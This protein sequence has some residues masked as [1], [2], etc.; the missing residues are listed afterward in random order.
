MPL[1]S[2]TDDCSGN[3]GDMSQNTKRVLVTAGGGGGGG[4]WGGGRK[5][6]KKTF[7]RIVTEQ[8]IGW[9]KCVNGLIAALSLLM[10]GL[11]YVH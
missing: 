5:K 1:L 11:M 8:F 4:R 9:M 10:S 3:S 6:K 7:V 2:G